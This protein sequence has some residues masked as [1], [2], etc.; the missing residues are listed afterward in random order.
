MTSV[1]ST[2]CSVLAAF[3]LAACGGSG[4]NGT[5]G[6]DGATGP[7]GPSG[8]AGVAGPTG[9]TGAT[10][11]SGGAA[12]ATGATG[13][14]GVAGAT[15]A[16]GATG[17]GP[18]GATGPTGT[19]VTWVGA[20][21]TTTAAPNTGYLVNGSGETI[22]L[23]ASGTLA[24]GDEIDI[25]GAGDGF[26]VALGGNTLQSAPGVIDQLWQNPNAGPAQASQD[27]SGAAS[28]S[29]GTNLAAVAFEGDIWTST[30]GGATWTDRTTATG[31]NPNAN[32]QFWASIASDSTGANLVALATYNGIWTTGRA[33]LVGELGATV[34]LVYLGAGAFYVTAATGVL[35]R[36]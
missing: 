5:N 34:N 13:A 26:T 23:P 28:D 4:T 6:T 27:W 15:G 35:T 2:L 33:S 25:T 31:S 7:T 1:R 16:T 11:S 9:A 21:T 8:V 18:P 20:T 12:G 24:F 17:T 32:N 19:G 36:E 30:N 22:T 3:A 14:T 29:T 10:G